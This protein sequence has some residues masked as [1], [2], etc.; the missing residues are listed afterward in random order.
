MTLFSLM[1]SSEDY[2]QSYLAAS[3]IRLIRMFFAAISMLLPSLY[4]T[5]TT[6]QTEMIPTDL[7]LTIASAREN[8]PFS[9]LTEALIMKLTFEGLREAGTRIPKLVIG[10]DLNMI[11][12][13]CTYK[14]GNLMSGQ[15]WVEFGEKMDGKWGHRVVLLLLVFWGVY[16]VSFDIEQFTLF[17]GTIYM[18]ETP[19]WF[20]QF[21]IG[22]VIWVTVRWGFSTLVYIADGAFII[23][24][25][26]IIF[27]LVIFSR[28]ANLQMLP[29]LV[30]H[31]DF[32]N[33]YK[34]ALGVV[35]WIGEWFIFL[36][37][38][39]HYPFD[40]KILR[41][42][43]LSNLL[44]T[45]AVLL[46]WLLVLLNF[47]PH[48]GSKLKYPILELI[49]STSSEGL[50][51]N[52]DPLFIGLWAS[53]LI[54][55]DAFLIYVAVSC[56]SRLLKIKERKPLITLLVGTA[57]VAAFQFS[58]NITSFQSQSS[59]LGFIAFW[60]IVNCIP[61]YYL[62]ILLFRGRLSKKKLT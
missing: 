22:I 13:L 5:I 6:F 18:R 32:R 12:V 51:G 44:V 60:I 28:D 26:G 52:A 3:W 57:T 50:V 23:T 55:H 61:V 43:M 19:P 56:L 17:Y 39:P 42:L 36:F 7:L 9:A 27:L 15:S 14:L 2:Y 35:S 21:I 54:I 16:Y 62:I 34:D 40:K 48:Y 59:E 49:L 33:V 20:L 11:L 25:L 8:I 31:H 58:R 38:M 46:T 47:G 10:G 29:A 41:Y 24:L 1:Q 30:T 45:F 53:S 4:V 37:I